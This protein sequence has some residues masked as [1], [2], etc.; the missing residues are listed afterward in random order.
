MKT[1]RFAPS[2]ASRR[3][4]ERS[5]ASGVLDAPEV[6]FTEPCGLAVD[7]FHSGLWRRPFF[8]GVAHLWSLGF[9]QSPESNLP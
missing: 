6:R 7:L 1:G 2:V 5:A 9:R 3:E 8:F 4:N